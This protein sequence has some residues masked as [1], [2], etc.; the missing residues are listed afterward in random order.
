MI[1]K[2]WFSYMAYEGY[3]DP[4][5]YCNECKVRLEGEGNLC[6]MEHTPDCS[7]VPPKD[8]FEWHGIYGVS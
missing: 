6:D 3:P 4:H 8:E 5:M 1:L 7:Y 2:K